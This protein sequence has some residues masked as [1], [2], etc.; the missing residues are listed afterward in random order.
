LHGSKLVR[1]ERIGEHGDAANGWQ[2]LLEQPEPFGQ[3][4]EMLEE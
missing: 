2:H 1:R 3:Q 4:F